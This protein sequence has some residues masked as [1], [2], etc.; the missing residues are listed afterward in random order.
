MS[1]SSF[2]RAGLVKLPTAAS[3]MNETAPVVL[4]QEVELSDGAHITR[5]PIG[6]AY[7]KVFLSFAAQAGWR[8]YGEDGFS[9]LRH[10]RVEQA[11]QIVP[12]GGGGGGG[13]DELWTDHIEF[14]RNDFK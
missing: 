6:L 3:G 7:G 9:S 1:G 12:P 11:G 13:S 14:D 2:P 5:F 10:V 4:Q 8:G